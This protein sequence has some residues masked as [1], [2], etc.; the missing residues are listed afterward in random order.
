MPH[1]KATPETFWAKVAR[2]DK[3]ACWPWI[4]RYTRRG[5]GALTYHQRLWNAHRLAYTLTYGPIPDGMMVCHS[6]D[7][8]LCCNPSHLWLGT[9][10]D[11]MHDAHVKGRM[12]QGE[13]W[14]DVHMATLARGER[15]GKY[16][17][18]ERSARGERV[19]TNKLTSEQVLAIRARYAQGGITQAELAH[20]YGVN[21]P[22]IYKIVHGLNWKHL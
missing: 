4:G 12:A 10:A 19:N 5:Y 17:H 16:T 2:S 8:T 20:E 21:K 15:N 18:P 7:N 6:C 13:H 1:I 9:N 14:R 22:A 3:D 11:N